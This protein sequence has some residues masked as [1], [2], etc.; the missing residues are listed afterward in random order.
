MPPKTRRPRLPRQSVT[1]VLVSHD[2]ARWLPDCLAALAGQTRPPHRVV[3]VDTGSEDNSVELLSDALGEAAVVTRPRDTSFGDAV[4]AGVACDA[5]SP[6]EADP[7]VTEWLWLLHDDCAPDR[8]ALEH[9]LDRAAESS[10]VDVVGPKVLSWDRRVLIEVGVTIDSSGHRETGLERRELDQGQ[11]DHVGDVLAVGTAGVLVRRSVWDALGGLDRLW[12]LAGDDVDFGWRV[13]SAGGRVVVASQAVVRHA[14]ALESGQRRADA[15]V[16]TYGAAARGH[17]MGVVLANTSA[18]LVLP[19][20]LRLVVETLLRA[21]GALLV[22]RSPRR[23]RDELVGLG[24]LAASVP[25]LVAARR[26]R[27]R[28]RQ[29]RHGD[30]HGLLAPASLRWRRA[31]DA[32]TGLFGGRAAVDERQRR[33]APV[34]TGPVSDEAE[35]LTTDDLGVLARFVTRPGVV[36][37]LALTAYALVAERHLLGGTLHGGRLLPAGGG[38]SD[39]WSQY[40]STW[41]SVELGSTTS[42]PPVLALLALVATLC[43]GKLWLAVDIVLLGAVPLAG[44]SAYLSSRG[45]SRRVPL[46]IWAAVGYALLP[47]LTGAV[48]GGRIDVALAAIL[49]PPAARVA[50]G[51]LARSAEAG[52]FTRAVGAGVLL[53]LAVAAA[54]MLWLAAAATVLLAALVGFGRAGLL[55]RVPVAAVVAVVPVLLLLPMTVRVVSHPSAMLIGAGLPETNASRRGLTAAQLLLLHPGGP[56]LP[57]LWV[58]SPIVLAAIVGLATSRRMVRGGVVVLVVGLAAALGISRLT[59]SG[60]VPDSRYWVGALFLVAGVGALVAATAAADRAPEALRRVAFGWRQAGVAV[61]VLAAVAGTATMAVAWVVRGADRPLTDSSPQVLPIFAQAEAAAATSPRTLLL[62]SENSVVHYSLLRSPT[63][64]T[65]G[66]ADVAASGA[67]HRRARRAL[68]AAVADA[69]AGRSRAAGELAEFGISLV[70]VPDDSGGALRNVA[71]VDGLARVPATTTTVY[72]AALDSGELIVLSGADGKTAAKGSTL[73]T[74][75]HPKPLIASPGSAR[76]EIAPASQQ[77]LLVLAEPASTAWRAQLSGKP[78]PATTAYGWAQA[79]RLPAGSQGSLIVRRAD[80]DRAPLLIA[81]LVLVVVAIAL[82]IPVRGG[83]R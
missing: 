38:A 71:A 34:E 44:I 4:A 66:D 26:Q 37:A 15:I 7:D 83:T 43:F 56:A 39:L 2:G 72:R 80:S 74:T 25:R 23:S 54:P 46:R 64:L 13:N 81:Q 75:S 50:A 18:W 58:W 57:P 41:H 35:S 45:L 32:I 11:H 10:S 53:T 19:L 29:R 73:S 69:A 20:A 33:R 63:G 65:L 14:R 30:I 17:G 79:W 49:L 12:A 60:V 28:L 47:P 40:V 27:A 3:A 55:R 8:N 68:A 36:L 16:A 24:I 82:S 48:T 1:A 9:L 31:G 70:V 22:L 62:R 61:I 21:L 67:D 51:S 76:T 6:A 5:A 42:A 59:P 78:L 52:A 77:R